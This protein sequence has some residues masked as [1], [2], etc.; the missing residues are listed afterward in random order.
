MCDDQ[1]V[2]FGLTRSFSAT[3]LVLMDASPL[4]VVGQPMDG[5]ARGHHPK[6]E[7]HGGS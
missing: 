3:D 7:H 5:P 1:T 6:E 2:V 4:V